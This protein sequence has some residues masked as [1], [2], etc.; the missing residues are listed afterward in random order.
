[1]PDK[2][3]GKVVDLD[4]LIELAYPIL[5]LCAL[6]WAKDF[7]LP[8]V[9]AILFSLLLTPAVSRLERWRFPPGLAVLSVLAI[10]FAIIGGLCAPMSVEALGL[11]NPFPNYPTTLHATCPPIHKTPPR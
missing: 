3:D 7:L 5:I 10:A 8:I 11:P 6:T 4:K 9:L 2:S 1:M